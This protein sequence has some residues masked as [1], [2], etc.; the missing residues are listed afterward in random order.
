MYP[1]PVEEVLLARYLPAGAFSLT[2]HML[3]GPLGSVDAC[4]SAG[5]TSDPEA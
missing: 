3:T 5:S 4:G 1:E 2:S